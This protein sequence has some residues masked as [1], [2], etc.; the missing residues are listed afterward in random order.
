MASR[1]FWDGCLGFPNPIELA[2]WE[3][4]RICLGT[5][6]EPRKGSGE[7]RQG[8]NSIRRLWHLFMDFLD[9][10][11]R[12]QDIKN[13][14]SLG[15]YARSSLF[16]FN[17]QLHSANRLDDI[18]NLD[19]IRQGMRQCPR[20]R[21]D[22]VEVAS[23]LLIFRIYILNWTFYH[24]QGSIRCRIDCRAIINALL[25]LHLS[26]IEYVTTTEALA[27]FHDD[28]CQVCHRYRKNVTAVHVRHPTDLVT[29]PVRIGKEAT[30]RISGFPQTMAWF[31]AQQSLHSSFGTFDHDVPGRVQC[32]ACCQITLHGPWKRNIT[33][34]DRTQR[35]RLRRE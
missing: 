10:E 22:L 30:R 14:D 35:K 33:S 26:E 18:A 27:G 2:L 12:Y 34:I 25:Q 15:K 32:F 28:I 13:S 21:K 1:V 5:G 19:Q 23:A 7:Q 11:S 6:I 17:T 8:G 9:G 31:E 16:R 24:Y 29:M 3:S 4:A 20:S